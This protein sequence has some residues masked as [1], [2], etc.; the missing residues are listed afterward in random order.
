MQSS[1]CGH[2]CFT[3]GA[4]GH[5][6]ISALPFHQEVRST[7]GQRSAGKHTSHIGAPE[8]SVIAALVATVGT[9]WG[10]SRIGKRRRLQV[11][12][13]SGVTE[14]AVTCPEQASTAETSETRVPSGPLSG[15]VF[16]WLSPLVLPPPFPAS[17]A[18]L[19]PKH[20]I[21]LAEHENGEVVAFDFEPIE[22][23]SLANAVRLLSGGSSPGK[24]G[25]RYLRRLPRGSVRVGPIAH[26]TTVE[27]IANSVSSSFDPN[28]S[29]SSNDC[30]SYSQTVLNRILAKP[31][32]ES[33]GR[34]YSTIDPDALESDNQAVYKEPSLFNA[35]VLV[36]GTTIGAGILALPAV[37]QPVGFVPSTAVLLGCWL[38][39]VA[40]GLLV[41]E[42]TLADMSSSGRRATSL[43]SM[44]TKTLGG[45]GS[46]ISSFAFV[47]V[48]VG[49]IIA[50]ISR[51]GELLCSIIPDLASNRA[52]A[53][54]AFTVGFGGLV[55]ATKGTDALEL[56]NNVFASIVL[57]SFFALMA[58]AL[59]S[60][61][62]H[63][64]FDVANW[65]ST[66]QIVPTM[67][68]SL[69]YHNV[70]PT[71][72]AQLEGDRDKITTAIIGGSFIPFLMFVLWN[73]AILAAVPPGISGVDPLE[74]LRASG[75]TALSTGVI[76]F[77]LSAI[78]TSFIGFVL[79]LTDF[80]KDA[81]S[82][83]GQSE[84]EETQLS[85]FRDFALTLVPPLAIA[86]YDPSLFFQ[87]LDKAGAF[88][89]S[90]L[91]GLLPAWMCLA[92]RA[93]EPLVLINKPG[94]L[95]GYQRGPMVFG[96]IAM[97]AG[98][99]GVA[100]AVIAQNTLELL[101]VV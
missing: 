32:S 85:R 13:A 61:E 16:L 26:G 60:A 25:L 59:P 9:R 76:A 97:L 64:L 73:G 23:E 55:Y 96:G 49:L 87:A 100:L 70:V 68:L 34:L 91:F 88:G 7:P 75:G 45:V 31:D 44:S 37:T 56:A 22:K 86:L 101:G 67:L 52:L 53:S 72:C 82:E 43:R 14:T 5:E 95:G 15:S 51:G 2:S 79:A 66:S 10:C 57:A 63:R 90:L 77:S 33:G 89:V 3:S 93:N 36:A 78:V 39:M 54:T 8:A 92:Q 17:I 41:A 65:Q 71:V 38:Y 12:R 81:L 58:C 4:T 42:V 69:V 48:H 74:V 35:I 21:V 6:P 46:A 27:D 28:L 1:G 47:I 20:S 99:G 24:F 84:A 11:D 18:Q 40:T 80:M 62:A 94:F 29:L 50:Y 83:P 98:I 30:N 19:L